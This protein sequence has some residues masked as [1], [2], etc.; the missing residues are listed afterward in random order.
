MFTVLKTL[1]HFTLHPKRYETRHTHTVGDCNVLL[2]CEVHSFE[3]H[4]YSRFFVVLHFVVLHFV[5]LH[6]Y[7]RFVLHFVVKKRAENVV[8]S[9]KRAENSSSISRRRLRSL[10]ILASGHFSACRHNTCPNC[11]TEI[12]LS[13]PTSSTS[14]RCRR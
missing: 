4:P 12:F 2:F 14:R 1:V 13:C 3:K 10:G 11:A 6:S 8:I 7:S 5:V 9:G